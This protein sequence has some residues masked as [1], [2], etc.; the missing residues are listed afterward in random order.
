MTRPRR[1]LRA[2]KRPLPSSD[3]HDHHTWIPSVLQKLIRIFERFKS[4]PNV[5]PWLGHRADMKGNKAMYA[6]LRYAIAEEVKLLASHTN[7]LCMRIGNPVAPG[8]MEPYSVKQLLKRTTIAK[9]RFQRAGEQIR[10]YLGMLSLYPRADQLASDAYVGY[11]WARR[12][13]PNGFK[14][15]GL[16]KDLV[17]ERVAAY[18]RSKGVPYREVLAA[19][20]V[21]ILDP[22]SE[23][24]NPRDVA[25]AFGM[26]LAEFI[27]PDTS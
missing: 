4:N 12:L 13:D 6:Q 8:K 7:I 22:G 23:P 3:W 17:R 15:F 27:A 16:Y 5:I 18:Q 25:H 1:K 20:G 24:L 21:V 14:K 19:E 10:K 2:S 26:T 11:A 9:R